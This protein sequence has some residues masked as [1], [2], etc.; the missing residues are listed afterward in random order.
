MDTLSAEQDLGCGGSSCGRLATGDGDVG[1]R[2]RRSRRRRRRRRRTDAG[3]R[4]DGLTYQERWRV[5]AGRR[6]CKVRLGEDRHKN[7]IQRPAREWPVQ[8]P[9]RWAQNGSFRQHRDWMGGWVDGGV[10]AWIV[11]LGIR[12]LSG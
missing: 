9:A 3:P 10:A 4:C 2:R 6:R 7:G 1:T 5:E 11:I 12:Q 8:Y